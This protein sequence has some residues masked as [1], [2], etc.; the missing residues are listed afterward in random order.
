MGTQNQDN[1]RLKGKVH[2]Q[3]PFFMVPNDIF[4]LDLNLDI[5]EKMV[6]IYLRRCANNGSIP[7]PSYQTIGDK[8]SMSRRKAIDVV[9]NLIKKD[10]LQKEKRKNQSNVYHIIPPKEKS[11]PQPGEQHSP[12]SESHS[13]EV[14]NDIHQ[15]SAQH[16]PNKELFIKKERKKETRT[17]VRE[18]S[19][20]NQSLS[21]NETESQNSKI[22]D[23]WSKYLGTLQL[24]PSKMSILKSYLEDGLTEK[25]IIEGIKITARNEPGN[26]WFYLKQC[27]NDWIN[28]GLKTVKEVKKYLKERGEVQSGTKKADRVKF[29]GKNK[30]TDSR[31]EKGSQ[32]E[33]SKQFYRQFGDKEDSQ[34]KSS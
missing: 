5:Y 16:S 23:A 11:Y 13:P 6:Y 31:K 8:C 33:S 18:N 2:A 10:F 28:N 29:Y 15:G 7:F 32:K 25:A 1:K 4:D 24:T 3:N 9:K 27:L 21:E 14:V 30:K 26:C 34:E 19:S 22:P 17:H 20:K 12:G